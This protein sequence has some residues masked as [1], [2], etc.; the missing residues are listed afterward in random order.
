MKTREEILQVGLQIRRAEELLLEAFRDGHIR[1]TIHTCL[2]QELIPVMANEFF[3]DTFWFSNHRGHGH[4]L[5]RTKDFAGLFAEILSR[6]GGVSNGVGGSQHLLTDE[7]MSNGI[8]GGQAGIAA[9]FSSGRNSKEKKSVMFIGDGTLG[10]G[11]LYE[12]WNIAAIEKARVLYVVEDNLVAQSTPSEKTFRGNLEMRVEGFGLKYL[13]ANDED[14]DSLE[15]GFIR[16]RN[17]LENQF[18]TVLHIQTK[19]LGPHSKGDDNRKMSDIDALRGKDLISIAL[20]RNE[21]QD[22]EDIIEEIE[23]I[24]ESVLERKTAKYV[25]PEQHKHFWGTKVSVHPPQKI[26][27]SMH[28]NES[29]LEI[30]EMYPDVFFLGEDISDDQYQSGAKYGGAFKIT[31][32]L[33]TQYPDRVFSTPISESGLTGYGIGIAFSGKPVIAEIMFGDFLTQNYDQ[34]VHQM[35]KIPT[36]YGRNVPL[37]FILRTA[38]G[39]GRGYGPTHSA[40]MDNTLVGLPSVVVVSVNQ[41]SNYKDILRWAIE[42]NVP[43]IILEPKVLYA[44]T[45]MPKI[46]EEYQLQVAESLGLHHFKPKTTNSQIVIV[47]HGSLSMAVLNSL[48]VLAEKHEVFVELVILEVINPSLPEFVA[49]ILESNG[50]R[51]VIV[52]ESIGGAGAGAYLLS[53]LLASGVSPYLLHLY[54]DDWHP[55]GILEE[56]LQYDSEKIVSSVMNWLLS[57]EK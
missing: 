43:A 41:F 46:Y 33:S 21:I 37:P 40:P 20:A 49:N 36:M 44:Q 47:T 13:S 2:G 7:F 10:A 55:S 28:I 1:G 8:Q 39:G 30:A 29:L 45:H 22:S 57:S 31:S 25:K 17:N 51:L 3:G 6:E 18:P 42:R 19:R 50:R 54:Q 12:A 38:V 11:H 4:Y 16:A 14:L 34:I 15:S 26:N 53:K 23:R 56:E 52:E 35:S 32:K 5:A 9:G 27:L 48:K 24:F